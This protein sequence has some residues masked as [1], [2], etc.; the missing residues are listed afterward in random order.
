MIER[1]NLGLIMSVIL[2]VI[3]GC[4]KEKT[5]SIN[6]NWYYFNSDSIYSEAYFKNGKVVFYDEDLGGGPMY[7]YSKKKDSI[8]IYYRD[9]LEYTY[10]MKFIG[11]SLFF[12]GDNQEY[13]LYPLEDQIDYFNLPNTMEAVDSFDYEFAQRMFRNKP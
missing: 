10:G 12:S 1:K 2:S 13:T 7:R 11:N 8:Y 6:G 4:V 3:L 5:T 9:S